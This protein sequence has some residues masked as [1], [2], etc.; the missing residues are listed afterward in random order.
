MQDSVQL[1]CTYDD[2]EK[3]WHV[4]FP[5]P[6]GGINVL[7]SFASEAEARSFWQEQIDSADYSDL[8]EE[9]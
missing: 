6:L 8:D 1:Y 3:E 5:N 7:Q 9:S 4:W 2:E